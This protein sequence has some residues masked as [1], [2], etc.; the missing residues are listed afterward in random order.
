LCNSNF[1]FKMRHFYDIRIQKCRDLEIRIRGHS[2][3]VIESGT[4]R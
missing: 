1:V 2:I 4:I 3:K